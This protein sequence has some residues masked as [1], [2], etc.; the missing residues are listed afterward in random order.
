[1][2]ESWKNVLEAKLNY[3][4]NLWPINDISGPVRNEAAAK[5]PSKEHNFIAV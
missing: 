4:A 1:M 5:S 2:L 3:S